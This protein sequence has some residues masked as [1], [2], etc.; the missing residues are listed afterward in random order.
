MELEENCD[1][2]L[3]Y[4]NLD[5]IEEN[6]IYNI[7]QLIIKYPLIWYN[8]LENILKNKI[9]ISFRDAALI[10]SLELLTR[11]L[12]NSFNFVYDVMVK[13]Q[14]VVHTIEKKGF[15]IIYVYSQK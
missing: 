13:S 12:R 14:V 5:H 11:Q 2:L 9:M 7:S 3:Y 15:L 1:F 8:F 10:V 4:S 6:F